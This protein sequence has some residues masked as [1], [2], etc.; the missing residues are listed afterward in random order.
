MYHAN[1]VRDFVAGLQESL[2][3]YQVHTE[4]PTVM[5]APVD[6]VANAVQNTLK[7]L[8]TQLQQMQ[9]MMQAMQMQYATAP[10][11]TFQDYGG[12]QYYVGRGYHGNQSSYL[13]RGGRGAQSN[14]NWRRGRGGRAKSNLTH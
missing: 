8:S 14:G 5:Q 2:Q 7:Q 9:A 3:Q 6:H 12:R 4:T 11:G 10:R 1:I 13:G